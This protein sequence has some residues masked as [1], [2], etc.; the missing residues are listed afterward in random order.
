MTL[1]AEPLSPLGAESYNDYTGKQAVLRSNS[2]ITEPQ[3]T[4]FSP[5]SWPFLLLLPR[6]SQYLEAQFFER[7]ESC[8]VPSSEPVKAPAAHV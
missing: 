3:D 1:L 7:S 8:S 4:D 2:F 6:V 5:T